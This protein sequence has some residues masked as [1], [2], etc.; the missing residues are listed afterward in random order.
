MGDRT[1]VFYS[2]WVEARIHI[3]SVN[4]MT[5][6]YLLYSPKTEISPILASL[7]HSGLQV[8]DEIALQLTKP[9]QHYLPN[10]DWHLDQLYDFLPDLGVTVLQAIYSRYVV[11]LNRS[12][13]EPLFGNFWRSPIPETTAFNV[14]LYETLPSRQQIEQRIE[15]YYRPYHQRLQQ[16]LDQLI[17][18]FGKVYLLDL[19][20]FLG[21]IEDEICLGNANGK[22]CSEFLIST[23]EQAFYSH[24]YQVVRNKVFKGGY[25]IRHYGKLPHVEA[26]QIEVRYPVYLNSQELERPQIPSFQVPEG[27]RAKQNFQQIFRQ[28]CQA[29]SDRRI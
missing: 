29:I 26:L 22:S 7:P 12:P 9:H 24:G 23:V 20:S 19:H 27:D 15:Q 25:I 10:Q 16:L 1:V 8:P 21:L 4:Q 11:D 18:K 14:P 17:E 2:M 6:P 3:F 5:I 28:I 13:T